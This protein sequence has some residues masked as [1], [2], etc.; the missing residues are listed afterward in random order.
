[1]WET[2]CISQKR[3]KAVHLQEIRPL[4]GLFTGANRKFA[5]LERSIVE[6]MARR[7]PDVKFLL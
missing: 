5:D 3:E 4:R 7:Y 2:L 1:M 6:L